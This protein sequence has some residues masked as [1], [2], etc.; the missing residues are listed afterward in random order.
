MNLRL[1]KNEVHI[2]SPHTQNRDRPLTQNRGNPV[3]VS[4]PYV[5]Q[6][7]LLSL[8][9]VKYV[10]TRTVDTPYILTRN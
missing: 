5:E 3:K 6:N 10:G 4:Y 7:I 8:A 9:Y 1:V 2:L